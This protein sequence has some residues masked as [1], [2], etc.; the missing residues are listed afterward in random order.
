M[1]RVFPLGVGLAIILATGVVHGI[2]TDRWGL[3]NE[4]ASSAAKLATVPTEIGEW[5]SE[6]LPDLDEQTLTVGE[7]AGYLNRSF[8]NSRTGARLSVLIV[9]G[10]PGPISQHSPEVCMGGEGFEVTKKEIDTKFPSAE[11]PDAPQ[12]WAGVFKKTDVA[13]T[14]AFRRVFWAWSTDDGVWTAPEHP[15]TKFAGKKALYKLYIVH[16]MNNANDSP[17]NSPAHELAKALLPQLQKSL[18]QDS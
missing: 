11:L 5:K 16:P 9:C 17:D 10:R 15:R 3:S 14:G 2:L 8:V 7:I 13:S 12:F 6:P 18:F 1:Q 4:P